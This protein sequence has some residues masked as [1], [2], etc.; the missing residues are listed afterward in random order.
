MP[1]SVGV[2]DNLAKDIALR[3]IAPIARRFA[4]QAGDVLILVPMAV[5]V[6][7]SKAS[8][9]NFDDAHELRELPHLSSQCEADGTDTKLWD[10]TIRFDVGFASR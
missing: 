8:L 7:A 6:L 10:R 9:V 3:A 5:F 4:R 2:L 1:A